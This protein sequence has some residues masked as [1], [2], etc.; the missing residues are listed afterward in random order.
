[1]RFDLIYINIGF[2]VFV[3]CVFLCVLVSCLGRTFG[4]VLSC[5]ASVCRPAEL[6]R[7]ELNIPE[8]V[9]MEESWKRASA[10]AA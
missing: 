4:Q 9:V 1:M 2:C 5:C 10:V 8:C 7:E 3:S 6:W